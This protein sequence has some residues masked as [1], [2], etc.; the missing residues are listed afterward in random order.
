MNDW[1]QEDR[2]E[3]G[4]QRNRTPDGTCKYALIRLDKLRSDADDDSCSDSVGAGAVLDFLLGKH[5]TLFPLDT[6]LLR[7][8]VELGGV[9]NREE[10]FVIKLKD[11]HAPSTLDQYANS[12][13][14]RG[15]TAIAD[16]VQALAERS[17]A[18]QTKRPD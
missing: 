3:Q 1:T 10:C 17:R 2:A 13:R 16:D 6:L 9:D 18:M 12:A 15:L 14:A 11:E 8:Y 4:L 7:K 5:H